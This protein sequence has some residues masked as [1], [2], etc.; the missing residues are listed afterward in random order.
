LGHGPSTDDDDPATGER[1]TCEVVGINIH[2]DSMPPHNPA[3]L[4]EFVTL[5][6]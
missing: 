1:E 2:P 3:G 4:F 6:G 5:A